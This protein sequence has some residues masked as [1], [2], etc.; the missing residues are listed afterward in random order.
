MVGAA[1]KLDYD[2][3]TLLFILCNIAK[4]AGKR[5]KTDLS[6][7]EEEASVLLFSIS[8]SVISIM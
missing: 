3:I 7:E 6:N 2:D 1:E 8:N 5:K 4:K